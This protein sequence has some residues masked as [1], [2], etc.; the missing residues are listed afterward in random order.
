MAGAGWGALVSSVAI[1]VHLVPAGGGGCRFKSRCASSAHARRRWRGECGRGGWLLAALYSLCVH[2]SAIL[3]ATDFGLALLALWPLVFWRVPPWAVV[4]AP[5]PGRVSTG[6]S[7]KENGLQR[8][9]CKRFAS[10]QK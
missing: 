5:R 1:F 9:S 6:L 2:Y 4:L 8:F 10:Y 7:F 3:G